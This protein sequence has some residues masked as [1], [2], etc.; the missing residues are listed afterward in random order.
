MIDI[1]WLF[2]GTILGHF[3]TF[4]IGYSFFHIISRKR[5][6]PPLQKFVISYSLGIGLIGFTMLIFIIIGIHTRFS[7]LPISLAA[8]GVFIYFK[9]HKSLIKEFRDLYNSIKKL[10]LNYI[11]LFCLILIIIE[12]I[13]I[14]SRNIIYPITY[15]DEYLIWDSKAIYLFYDGNFNYFTYAAETYHLNYPPLVSLFVSFFYS[16]YFTP[17]YFAKFTSTAVFICLIVYVYYF[18]RHF[19]L[20]RTYSFLLTTFLATSIEVFY[21]AVILYADLTLALFFTISTVFTLSYFE[22]KDKFNLI[23][24]SF[25]MGFMALTKQEGLAMLVINIGTFAMYELFSLFKKEK[26]IKDA[27]ESIIL[28]SLIAVLIY[29]PWPIF[30]LNQNISDAY[31]ANL[32]ILFNPL[33]LLSR[34]LQIL[35]FFPLALVWVYFWISFIILFFLVLRK[36]I[37]EKIPFYILIV[38]TLQLIVYFIIYLVTPYD[39][40]GQYFSSINRELLHMTP[41]LMILLGILLVKN[42]NLLVK[43]PD[44]NSDFRKYIKYLSIAILCILIIYPIIAYSFNMFYFMDI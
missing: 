38:C 35:S 2:I 22:T 30:T 12:F 39:L 6:F 1:I 16:I 5:H 40:E 42:R 3:I 7:F 27:L 32:S 31:S 26:K 10:K 4:F 29:I 20:N 41:I 37:F 34:I 24:A 23:I 13:I 11:E 15:M 21:Q 28:L 8:L 9:L 18:L 19:N 33:L 36:T 17:F 44:K 43:N 25:F 14:I